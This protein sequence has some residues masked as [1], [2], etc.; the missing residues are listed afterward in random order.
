MVMLSTPPL[1]VKGKLANALGDELQRKV[2]SV[3]LL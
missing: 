1:M 3:L 2:E